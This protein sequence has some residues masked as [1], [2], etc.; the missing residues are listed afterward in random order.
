MR[1]VRKVIRL[2]VCV[3]LLA[4]CSFDRGWPAAET[5]TTAFEPGRDYYPGADRVSFRHSNQLSASYHGYYKRVRLVTNGIGEEFSFVFVRREA[6]LPELGADDIVIRVPLRRYSLG[7]YRYG[8]I[9]ELLGVTDRLVGFGNHTHATTPSI[10]KMFERGQL[11]RNT[12][13]EALAHRG[14]EAHFNWYATSALSS[15]GDTMARLGTLE[16]PAAEHMEPTPLAR[17]EWIKFFAMFFDKEREAN[18]AFDEIERNYT[19]VQQLVA[20]VTARPRVFTNLGQGGGW[21]IH[22]GRNQLAR[23]LGDAGGDYVWSDDP[24]EL[25]GTTAHDE[26]ALDRGLDAEVWLMS[27]EAVF[28]TRIAQL[29]ISN[30]RFAAFKSVRNGRVYVNHRNYPDGPN[31]W[32]DY[33]L[34]QPDRE[35]ADLIA[36]FHPHLLPDHEF[37]FWRRLTTELETRPSTD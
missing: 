31:P 17:A 9:S 5:E 3:A 37:T 33:A 27:A 22:G 26:S 35:L 23:I 25:S 21:S 28:G 15:A 6:P 11:Q 10:V 12:D 14:T 34:I 8:G 20:G 36:I 24:S 4:G 29:S 2:L 13:L 30:P 18:Q 19:R 32:W 1:A 16:I 7:S